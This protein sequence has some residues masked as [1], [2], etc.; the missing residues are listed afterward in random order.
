VAGISFFGSGPKL[1]R[2][3]EF[4]KRPTHGSK[5]ESEAGNISSY[6]VPFLPISW[7]AQKMLVSGVM[8]QESDGKQTASL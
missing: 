3:K 6:P 8:R 7:V 5:P 4:V 2:E 1:L